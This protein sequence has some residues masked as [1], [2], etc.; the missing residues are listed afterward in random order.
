MNLKKI[1]IAIAAIVSLQHGYAQSISEVKE[2]IADNKM[3]EAKQMMD[4]II[5]KPEVASKSEAWYHK[6]VAENACSKEK[7]AATICKDCKADAFASFK[8]YMAMDAKSFLMKASENVQL[9]DLYN[10]FL[11]EGN[12]AY[13]A[14]DLETAYTKFCLANDVRTFI[15]DKKLEYKD[16][17]F[18]GI[19]TPLMTNIAIFAI[20]IKKYTAAIDI[21]KTL[22]AAKAAPQDLGTNCAIVASNAYAAGNKEE[23]IAFNEQCKTYFTN[24]DIFYESEMQMMDVSDKKALHQKFEKAIAAKPSSYRL[25]FNYLAEL[26]NT[27]HVDNKDTEE[28]KLIL[29]QKLEAIA[30]KTDAINHTT[31]VDIMLCKHYYNSVYDMQEKM[32]KM[33]GST[34]DVVAAKNVLK[35]KLATTMDACIAKGLAAESHYTSLPTMAEGD[36]ENLKS[37]LGI[38]KSAYGQKANTAKVAEYKA[39]VDGFK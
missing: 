27:L 25:H 5:V 7:D 20:N 10:G 33:T 39:K 17:K 13:E 8:K 12:T 29:L 22:M 15:V 16:T 18:T 6:G 3:K 19:D 1:A 28:E 23:A 14:K 4:A 31:D 38:L 2:L 26:F 32:R 30:A 24:N 21:Y 37:I 9:F 35:E 34:K 36:K 11:D